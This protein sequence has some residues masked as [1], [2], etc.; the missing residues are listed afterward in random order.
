MALSRCVLRIA[1]QGFD[2][3]RRGPSEVALPAVPP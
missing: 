1:G 2:Q 3:S